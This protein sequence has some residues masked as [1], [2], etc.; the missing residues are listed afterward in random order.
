MVIRLRPLPLAIALLAATPVARAAPAKNPRIDEIKR[1]D[2]DVEAG[3]KDK[4]VLRTRVKRH[5]VEGGIGEHDTSFALDRKG[6]VLRQ[7]TMEVSGQVQAQTNRF[8]FDESGE[9][10]FALIKYKDYITCADDTLIVFDTER[11]YFDKGALIRR[12]TR[13]EQVKDNTADASKCNEDNRPE[14]DR[15][16]SFSKGD[17]KLAEMVT[18]AAKEYVSV[19]KEFPEAKINDSRKKALI[20]RLDKIAKLIASAP[21]AG[22]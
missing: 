11:L 10:A 1:L 6:G 19:A 2:H 4:S 12:I 3:I 18:A 14:R 15:Q 22:K 16:E 7:A 8:V 13:R 20:A 5:W 9:L 21:E 17:L